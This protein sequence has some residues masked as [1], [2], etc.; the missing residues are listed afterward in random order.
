MQAVN[1]R[2]SSSPAL[3]AWPYRTR[4]TPSSHHLS[5]LPLWSSGTLP[6]EEGRSKQTRQRYLGSSSP[7]ISKQYREGGE[8]F[9]PRSPIN[10]SQRKANTKAV[11][12][13]AEK[14]FFRSERPAGCVACLHC[15]HAH[16]TIAIP[17]DVL[18]FWLYL[19]LM[20]ELVQ[21]FQS[22][23]ETQ[24]KTQSS[25]VERVTAYSGSVRAT[26]HHQFLKQIL[27]I[28]ITY[29]RIDHDTQNCAQIA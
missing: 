10:S 12:V 16:L 9:T 28:C 4:Q 5:A 21:A 22:S 27:G 11:V 1:L 17:F 23:F 15:C 19:V 3:L 13:F 14:K 25:A 20:Q 2:A 8:G 6:S 29:L 24:T 18:V 7:F 26:G